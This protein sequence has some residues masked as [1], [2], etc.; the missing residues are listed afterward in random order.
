PRPALFDVANDNTIGI[1]QSSQVILLNSGA[2]LL[3]NT[4][5]PITL[6]GPPTPPGSQPGLR[7]VLTNVYNAL[8]TYKARVTDP[9]TW[10]VLFTAS[11]IKMLATKF[12]T[13]LNRDPNLAAE[14][15]K[16]VDPLINVAERHR[17]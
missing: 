5:V 6:N 2:P 15:Q 16:G 7:V 8:V 4:G 9:S 17:G 12:A 14:Q 13:A 3:L 1:N 10:D 11:L